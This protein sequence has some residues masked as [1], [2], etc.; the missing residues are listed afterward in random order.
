MDSPNPSGNVIEIGQRLRDADLL[1][2]RRI[3]EAAGY[4]V[5]SQETAEETPLWYVPTAADIPK[6]LS[7]RG[8]R[9][10]NIPPPL[11]FSVVWLSVLLFWQ[12]AVFGTL[13]RLL[14]VLRYCQG[15]MGKGPRPPGNA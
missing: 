9:G 10:H 7:G 13:H 8:I 14:S 15:L 2:A 3:V 6:I 5:V 11:P 12:V 4:T 1:R